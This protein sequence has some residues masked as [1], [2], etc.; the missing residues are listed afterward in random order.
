MVQF[1]ENI[2]RET[3]ID[4]T[5]KAINE[6]VA[7]ALEVKGVITTGKHFNVQL[8]IDA[9]QLYEDKFELMGGQRSPKNQIFWEHIIGRIRDFLPKCYAQAFGQNI[10][11]VVDGSASLRRDFVPKGWFLFVGSSLQGNKGDGRRGAAILTKLY[12]EKTLALQEFIQ[13]SNNKTC[14]IL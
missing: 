13:P 11:H 9:F 6:F 10:S 4:E 2:S 7:S 5:N 14:S 3:E 8:L 12:R 1:I